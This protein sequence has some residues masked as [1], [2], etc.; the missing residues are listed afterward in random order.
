MGR[1]LVAGAIACVVVAAAGHARAGGDEAAAEALFVEAKKLAAQKKYAEACPKF[2]ESNRL[3]RGAGTLIHLGDCYEKNKQTASAWATYKEAASAAQA[4]GRKDW[5]KLA[6]QRA[7]ALE[8]KLARLTIKVDKDNPAKL[9]V[10]RGGTSV[11]EASFGVPIPVDVGTHAVEAT[12]PGHK[13]FSTSATVSKDGESVEVTVPKLEAEPAAVAAEPVEPPKPVAPPP[14]KTEDDGSGQRTLGF[15]LGGVGVAGLAAGAVTGLMAMGKSSD[16][17]A[18]CPNDGPCASR[19][20]VD[21]S[22]SARTLGLVSTIA[23]VA[24][25]VGLAAGAALVFTAKGEG[26]R[27]AKAGRV[28]V[29]PNAGPTGAGFTV[30]GVF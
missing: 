4:L 30:L 25:G 19:D 3:D 29:A 5:E 1:T 11:A 2:A 26:D 27:A 10:S 8:P 6:S 9:E 22:E 20:A 7:S 13:P 12:A 28:R 21:A 17:K 15:V 23:F 14:E 24:G 16:A 18:T